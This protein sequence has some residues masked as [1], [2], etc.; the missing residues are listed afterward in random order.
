MTKRFLSAVHGFLP[1]LRLSDPENATLAVL[2]VRLQ[3]VHVIKV[4]NIHARTV[5]QAS[6][7]LLFI[8]RRAKPSYIPRCT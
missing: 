4:F 7:I 1:S 2:Q 6:S 3:R 5:Q 8:Y